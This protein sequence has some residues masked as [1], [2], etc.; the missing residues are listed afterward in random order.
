[1]Y[2]RDRYMGNPA[3]AGGTTNTQS[4]G[5]SQPTANAGHREWPH[6]K[7]PLKVALDSL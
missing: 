4:A 3:T 1:M 6:C 5:Q 2:I 7:P